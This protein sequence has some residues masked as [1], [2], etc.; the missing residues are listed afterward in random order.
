[1]VLLS[2]QEGAVVRLEALAS[3][4]IGRYLRLCDE[5]ERAWRLFNDGWYLREGRVQFVLSSSIARDCYRPC[6]PQ[7]R[8][9]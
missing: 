7:Q 4:P 8:V 6:M 2:K 1:M 3:S 9:Q 5:P